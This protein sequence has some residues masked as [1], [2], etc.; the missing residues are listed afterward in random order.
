MGS[1]IRT[2][3]VRGKNLPA[4]K[5]ISVEASD[6]L[7]GGML[8]NTE[9]KFAKSFPVTT[10]EQF[11]EIF[12]LQ[13]TSTDYGPDAVKGFFDNVVGV[14][15][16]LYIQSL[17][18]YSTGAIDSLISER[19]VEDEGADADAYLIQPAYED[20]LQYGVNGD[21][22]GSKITQVDRFA[23]EAS[24]TCA[25]TGQSYAELDSVIGISVGDI[26]LFKTG[27]G[28]ADLVYKKV[29]QVDESAKKVYWT[30]NFEVSGGSGETLA[31]ND[32][33]T[34]PGFTIQIYVKSVNGVETE[35]DT[36]IGQVICSSESEVTDFYVD[37]VFK[38]SK[39]LKVT[40]QSASTLGDRLPTEDTTVQYCA[41]GSDGTAVSDSTGQAF[42]L[43]YFNNDPIRFLANPET[44]NEAMQKGLLTYSL[45][46]GD[47]PI[48]ILNLAENR[49]KSQLITLGQSYQ[50]SDFSPGV[51][52]ANW[53]KVEDP[54]SNSNIAPARNVPCVGHVMGAWIWTIGTL[55]IH[56]IPA[57]SATT[58]K[59]ALGVVGDT[60]ENNRDRTEVAEAG[61]NV[62][63]E[64][65]GTGIKIMN[66][67]TISTDKAYL[68][69]NGILMRNFIKVSG[70][71]SLGG[72]ENTPNSLN[73]IKSDKMAMLVFLYKLWANGSTG[74]VPEGETFGQSEDE[75]NVP[76]AP[77][78]HFQV[79]ADL[80]NNPQSK[81]DS[82]ERNIW[83]YFTYPAPA[84]SIE[85]GVGILL[86]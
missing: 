45:G 61:V 17:L 43:E 19:E 75:N 83:V 11:A 54:F 70:V 20:E 78:D 9:R 40:E 4:K 79:I 18:G 69:G 60:L 21:R 28:G 77:E 85:I 16:T 8:L 15:A 38:A 63:Q 35:V 24:A 80:T 58:I 3:G 50:V 67:F 5:T 12:G 76:T 84:G 26:I 39:W 25:A 57:T 22:I 29:T 72:S 47:N 27:V 13:I 46:R 2:L 49:T 14:D 82:G 74:T 62:I 30:G 64:I 23:T 6:F 34:I 32:E 66:L 10:P 7:I 81:I 42:F 73:K 36:E 51:S 52:V 71:D 53:L 31:I 33:V 86:R 37:N 56:L 48:V 1:N 41:G 59:G 65:V 44:T 55:G 68:F